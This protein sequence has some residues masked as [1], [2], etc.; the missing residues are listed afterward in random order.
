MAQKWEYV[1]V[2]LIIHA[3]KQI[4][5]NWGSEGWEL[6][7]VVTGPDGNGL[8]AYMKRPLEDS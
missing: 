7:Q 3:T 4:L 1:T 6:V 5:D 2:P 8:V